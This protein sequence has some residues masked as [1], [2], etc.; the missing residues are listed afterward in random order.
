MKL[1]LLAFVPAFICS[2]AIGETL[3]SYFPLAGH[4]VL[5][6][7]FSELG[8]TLEN[9]V[10]PSN[11][12]TDYGLS[13]REFGQED[14]SLG[15]NS[16]TYT[17]PIQ[18]V[19]INFEIPYEAV[20]L[21]VG[22]MQPTVIEAVL[23]E[24]RVVSIITD[25]GDIV[26][27]RYYGFAGEVFDELRFYHTN[28]AELPFDERAFA[29]YRLQLGDLPPSFESAPGVTRVHTL[30]SLSTVIFM[31]LMSYIFIRKSARFN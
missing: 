15:I 27:R 26:S 17:Q 25:G 10:A 7:D 3:V 11:T 16:V 5:D 29:I 30:T 19:S 28:A 14:S 1:L 23:D 4:L 8:G 21:E 31:C 24:V 6:T 13:F 9:R 2:P 18:Y 22:A 12:Y 20:L